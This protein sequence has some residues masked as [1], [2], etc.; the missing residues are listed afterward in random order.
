MYL[1]NK[2]VKFRRNLTGLICALIAGYFFKSESMN[3]VF[4]FGSLAGIFFISASRLKIPRVTRRT[5]T[6]IRIFKR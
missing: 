4:L 3:E 1:S 5:I 2:E 6:T